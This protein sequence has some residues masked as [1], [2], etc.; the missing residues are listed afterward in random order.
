MP[1]ELLP[2]GMTEAMQ[3]KAQARKA[4]ATNAVKGCLASLSVAGLIVVFVC[5][6]ALHLAP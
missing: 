5:L 3:A 2:P 4:A 6:Y 1:I